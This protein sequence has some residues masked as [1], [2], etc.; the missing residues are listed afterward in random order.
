MSVSVD[1]ASAVSMSGFSISEVVEKFIQQQGHSLP[2]CIAD[3]YQPDHKLTE[4][5]YHLLPA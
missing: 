1:A 4:I 3:E 5:F 2:V